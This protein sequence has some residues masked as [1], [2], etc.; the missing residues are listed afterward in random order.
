MVTEGG[1]DIVE[2][3]GRQANQ[4]GQ[5]LKSWH[6]FSSIRLE[7]AGPDKAAALGSLSVPSSWPAAAGQTEPTSPSASASDISAA[8]TVPVSR[9]PALT[10]QQTLMEMMTG[11]PSNTRRDEHG[12]EETKDN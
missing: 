7:S 5:S 12:P 6:D 1:R 2:G 9:S 10:Y 3:I 11:R 8:P 4:T